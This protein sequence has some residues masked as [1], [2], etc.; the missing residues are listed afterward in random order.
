M[1]TLIFLKFRIWENDENFVKFRKHV[2]KVFSKK[3]V[4]NKIE[5][6]ACLNTEWN[7]WSKWWNAKI[8]VNKTGWKVCFNTE[9]VLYWY[10]YLLILKMICCFWWRHCTCLFQDVH[11]S[12][13]IASRDSQGE[14]L[15]VENPAPISE[16]ERKRREGVWELFK[17]ELI[18]LIDHLMVLKHVRTPAVPVSI[19]V[20]NELEMCA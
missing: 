3:I 1:E 20:P 11:W 4:V 9:C 6:K 17:S 14:P 5:W 19:Q 12:D 10:W 18:F 13:L 7:A 16:T 2:E 15:R 8:V